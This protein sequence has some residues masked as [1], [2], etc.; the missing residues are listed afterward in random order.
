MYSTTHCT[1]R[2]GTLSFHSAQMYCITGCSMAY[3]STVQSVAQQWIQWLDTYHTILHTGL[4][5]Q[6]WIGEKIER[7]RVKIHTVTLY[8][9]PSGISTQGC[10]VCSWTH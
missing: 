6:T 9:V 1:S 5:R 2:C 4:P 3:Y 7:C 8:D 10:G